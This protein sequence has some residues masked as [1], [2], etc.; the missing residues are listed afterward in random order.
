M[1]HVESEE[2]D[3]QGSSSIRRD[4]VKSCVGHAIVR[5]EQLSGLLGAGRVDPFSALPPG[6]GLK[7]S[8]IVDHCEQGN[9]CGSLHHVER[10]EYCVIWN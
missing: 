6:I 1:G 4:V 9:P 5:R 2:A 7:S 10:G 3:A 8:Q